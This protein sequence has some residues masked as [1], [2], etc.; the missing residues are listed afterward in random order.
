MSPIEGRS[1]C[2]YM[3]MSE[4]CY[5]ILC[6]QDIHLHHVSLYAD[7]ES[8]F[9]SPEGL[10][11]D[12]Y[13]PPPWRKHIVCG[14]LGLGRGGGCCAVTVTAR[15]PSLPHQYKGLMQSD[16][17]KGSSW[18]HMETLLSP[19]SH[20]SASSCGSSAPPPVPGVQEEGQRCHQTFCVC[21]IF[22][23]HVEF[24]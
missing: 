7:N 13:L 1:W 9:L 19:H 20:V 8:P 23:W 6:V 4:R 12:T 21:F 2:K 10:M 14:W 3:R 11:K 22:P 17:V 15:V 18:H 16:S 24:T 5:P